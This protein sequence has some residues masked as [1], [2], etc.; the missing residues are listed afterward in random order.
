[1]MA[2]CLFG[3]KASLKPKV[4]WTMSALLSLRG[5]ES[6]AECALLDNRHLKKVSWLTAAWVY[7]SVPGWDHIYVPN[8]FLYSC[9]SW[10]MFIYHWKPKGHID[11]L[12]VTCCTRGCH[13]DNLRSTQWRKGRQCDELL[14][15]GIVH[16][17]GVYS[18]VQHREFSLIFCHIPQWLGATL[19]TSY[20]QDEC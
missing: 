9:C 7:F 18:D 14:V 16:P 13:S 6:S 2:W 20:N 11:N 19:A 8:C 10:I 12:L 3:V 15:S 1:M 4:T 17:T 5:N